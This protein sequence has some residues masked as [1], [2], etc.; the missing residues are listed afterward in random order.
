MTYAVRYTTG[1]WGTRAL[2]RSVVP[3]PQSTF[4]VYVTLVFN[5]AQPLLTLLV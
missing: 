4:R 3:Y 1:T 5:G 2:I